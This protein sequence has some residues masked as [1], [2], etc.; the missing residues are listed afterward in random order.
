MRAHCPLIAPSDRPK[1]AHRTADLIGEVN[2]APGLGPGP[3]GSFTVTPDGHALQFQSTTPLPVCQHLSRTTTL[4]ASSRPFR[5]GARRPTVA[6]VPL[7]SQN[8]AQTC[9]VFEVR[10]LLSSISQA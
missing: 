8:L 4:T 3:R 7:I 5:T 9:L 1:T 6:K 10:Q 2:S